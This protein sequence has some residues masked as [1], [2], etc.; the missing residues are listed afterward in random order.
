MAFNWL[1]ILLIVLAYQHPDLKDAF[2]TMGHLTF[3]WWVFALDLVVFGLVLRFV[4]RAAIEDVEKRPPDPGTAIRWNNTTGLSLATLAAVILPAIAWV[5]PQFDTYPTEMPDANLR[6]SAARFDLTAPDLRWS[7]H[8]PGSAWEQRYAVQTASGTTVEI[9][10]N[11]Y[12]EQSQGSE[13][14]SRGSH[15]FDPLYFASGSSGIVELRDSNG[16][17]LSA[18]RE[19]LKDSSGTSWVSVY[20]YLVD[21]ESVPGSHSIQL[22][23]ALRSTYSRTTAGVLAVAAQCIE[24]CESRNS[25]IENT[26]ILAFE[27]YRAGLSE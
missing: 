6:V 24:E 20:T 10:G 26:F 17:P 23:T 27:A 14:I 5:L 7:P 9:Y 1:R 2:E 13:L 15:L 3:G 22:K 25:D 18:H 4:P 8:Y 16:K 11:Q 19:I 12:H 21:N